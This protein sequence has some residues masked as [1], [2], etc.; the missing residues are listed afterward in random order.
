MNK[1]RLLV[2]FIVACAMS[3]AVWGQDAPTTSPL[4]YSGGIKL[5]KP[6]QSLVS[7]S[8]RRGRP[9]TAPTCGLQT[10]KA[11]A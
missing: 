5:T 2:V 3:P 6:R 4:Q 1:S 7:A 10:P 8:S 9:L 11:V